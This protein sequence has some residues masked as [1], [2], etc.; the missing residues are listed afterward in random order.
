MTR[1]RSTILN[2]ISQRQKKHRGGIRAAQKELRRA[3]HRQLLVECSSAV[4]AQLAKEIA[5]ARA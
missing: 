2:D 1:S 3:L 5:E 4:H